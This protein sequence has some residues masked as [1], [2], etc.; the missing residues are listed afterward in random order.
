MDYKKFIREHKT[1]N[2]CDLTL[3]L[4]NHQALSNLIKDMANPFRSYQIDKVVALEA[5]GFI[6]GA[7]IAQELKS[8]LC[9]IRK[10]N[11]I[12]W[13]TI[14]TTCVDYTNEEK[15]FEIA[16]D[17]IL[18]NENVLIVDDWSETGAQLKAA[19][20]LVEQAKG[21][22][23]GITCANIDKRVKS[24]AIISKYKVYSVIN[25]EIS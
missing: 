17:A 7:A 20:A 13:E 12:A 14:T 23:V 16:K 9:L 21:N 5:M 11:K 24:D 25:K 3:L 6:F 2:R 15:I 8:G 18:P 19:I 10:Q 1:K 4:S 22:I